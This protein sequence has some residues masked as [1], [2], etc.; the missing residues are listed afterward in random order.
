MPEDINFKLN[1]V[2]KGNFE[3][4]KKE[5]KKAKNSEWWGIESVI[6]RG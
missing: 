1:A 6:L 4:P 3:I 5:E 2:G